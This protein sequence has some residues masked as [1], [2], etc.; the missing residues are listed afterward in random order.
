MLSCHLGCKENAFF[1]LLLLLAPQNST[2]A[3][4]GPLGHLKPYFKYAVQRVS[5]LPIYI[6]YLSQFSARLCLSALL[7]QV[8]AAKPTGLWVEQGAS[9][10]AW[11]RRTCSSLRFGGQVWLACACS[12]SLHNDGNCCGYP[13]QGAA[14]AAHRWYPVAAKALP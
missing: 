3:L 7:A 2:K 4:C 11:K 1:L 14:G 10:Q 8:K 13:W 5:K 12:E 9:F 6:M